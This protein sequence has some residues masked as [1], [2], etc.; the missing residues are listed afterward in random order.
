M[1]DEIKRKF[2]PAVVVSIR[3]YHMDADKTYREKA[4]REL[5]KNA[6]SYTEQ[7]LE[8]T[9]HET[10]AVWP[11]LNNPNKTKKICGTLLE[12]QGRTHK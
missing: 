1:S 6:T 5:H 12:K 11:L 3:M 10:P 2:F 8:V 4:R 9:S 7:T